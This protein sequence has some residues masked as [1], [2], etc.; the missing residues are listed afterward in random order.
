MVPLPLPLLLPQPLPLPLPLPLLL[1]ARAGHGG[2]VIGSAGDGERYLGLNRVL[3]L[4]Y[5]C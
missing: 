3:S 4:Q 5:V 1:S 2:D